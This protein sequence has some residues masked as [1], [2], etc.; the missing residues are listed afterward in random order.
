VG[1]LRLD[2]EKLAVGGSPGMMLVVYHAEPGSASAERLA[3][4]ASAALP[5]HQTDRETRAPR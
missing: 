5:E 4:L 1:P 2:R 3:L